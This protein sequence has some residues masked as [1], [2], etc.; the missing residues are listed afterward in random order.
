MLRLL[1]VKKLREVLPIMEQYFK[2]PSSLVQ[3]DIVY[4]MMFLIE[5][6]SDLSYEC[7]QLFFRACCVHFKEPGQLF[8]LVKKYTVTAFSSRDRVRF[9]RG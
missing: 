2:N 5:M 7:K 4:P 3:S 6:E 8:Q 1:S 9:L